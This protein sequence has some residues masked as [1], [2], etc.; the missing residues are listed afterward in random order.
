V[1][2]F[3][4]IGFTMKWSLILMAGFG[5]YFLT[6]FLIHGLLTSGAWF[7][8][9]PMLIAYL[10][11]H[12]WILSSSIYYLTNDS[13]LIEYAHNIHSKTKVT[14]YRKLN[15][16]LFRIRL[17]T[18]EYE[19]REAPLVIPTMVGCIP[20][21]GRKINQWMNGEYYCFDS[22]RLDRAVESQ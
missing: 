14:E 9:V 8:G 22:G 2:I 4:A 12:S 21:Y 15:L 3:E 6:W 5:M 13:K 18:K 16:K 7:F 20:I 19:K 1:K 11:A 10:W 17:E